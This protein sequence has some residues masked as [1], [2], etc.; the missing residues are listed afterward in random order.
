MDEP[1]RPHRSVLAPPLE[2]PEYPRLRLRRWRRS[3]ALRAL[4]R[5]TELAPNDFVLPLFIVPG[6]GIRRPVPSLPGVDQTSPDEAVRDARE[7]WDLGVPAVLLFG[8]PDAKDPW[9]RSARDPNG[10]VPTAIR[11]LK[12]ALPELAII[13]DVCLCEYTD[14]GHCGVV[15]GEE[16]DNDATLPLLAEMAVV[17]AQAGADVVAPS[18]MMDGRVR[19]IRS[20]LDDAGCTHVAILS[21]AVKYASAFYGP[22]RDAAHN[23]P[24]FGDRRGYQMDP[25]NAEEALREAWLD[26]REG[27]DAVIV[28][29]AGPCLDIVRRL[30]DS[31]GWP[32]FG[33]QVSG[34][35]A[36]LCAAAERGWIDGARAL[37]EATLA[38]RRAGADGVIT[39]AAR[40]LARACQDGRLRGR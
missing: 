16:V 33:Y 25:A 14:H 32:E 10:V 12:D 6:T 34:E 35:Y 23:A 27:A 26:V 20:A 3:E 19:A 37:W 24:A 11:Q 28:K 22:F 7:A 5:E 36:M 21:Y 39:Y 2:G 38:I 31:L 17:L 1:R 18:D 29:P 15:V 30:K 9:A 8:V 4:V 13:A 40:A